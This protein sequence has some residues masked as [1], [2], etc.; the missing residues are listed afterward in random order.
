MSG[1]RSN[2][3]SVILPLICSVLSVVTALLY[4][5]WF[6]DSAE[7]NEIAF[8][9]MIGAGVLGILA[10]IGLGDFAASV[11]FLML[12]AGSMF[13]IYG[14]YYYVSIV[15]V[16]IDLQSF[17]TAFIACSALVGSTV[18]LSTLNVLIKR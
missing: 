8:Y 15:L 17:S 2:P 12:L 6:I 13:Y 16:G 18:A 5:S 9:L 1:F 4:R 3:L 7:F 11:Q 10:I 14:M